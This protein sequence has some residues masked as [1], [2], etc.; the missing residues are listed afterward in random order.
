MTSALKIQVR[1][2]GA[3]TDLDTLLALLGPLHNALE[4]ELAGLVARAD[5]GT[6]GGVL[7]PEC[8]AADLPVEE[9]LRRHVLLHLSGKVVRVESTTQLF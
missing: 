6:A 1:E 2:L 9:L 7:E 8:V 3:Q 4:E 5:E